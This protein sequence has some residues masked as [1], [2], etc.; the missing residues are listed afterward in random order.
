[1]LT[2]TACRLLLTVLSG[3]PAVSIG[4]LP[5]QWSA[6]PKLKVLSLGGNGSNMGAMPTSWSLMPAIAEIALTNMSI[7]TGGCIMKLGM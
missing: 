7:S 1:M 4:P 5:A 3:T 2:I 6:F